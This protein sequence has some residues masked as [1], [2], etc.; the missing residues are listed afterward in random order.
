MGGLVILNRPICILE[1]LRSILVFK[2]SLLQFDIQ[3]LNKELLNIVD[4]LSRD[5]T[6]GSFYNSLFIIHFI[7]TLFLLFRSS[8]TLIT[9]IGL[10]RFVK[11]YNKV[12]TFIIRNTNSLWDDMQFSSIILFF[13]VYT[14]TRDHK[15]KTTISFLKKYL[16][17]D[18]IDLKKRTKR[19][20]DHWDC[21]R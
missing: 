6:Q 17:K 14:C 20:V 3:Y 18:L 19:R 16:I 5:Q 2:V 12:F 9:Q 4:S 1:D 7:C 11:R 10:L 15:F 8:N 13:V 21:C